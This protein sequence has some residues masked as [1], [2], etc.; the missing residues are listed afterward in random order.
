MI[1]GAIR[2]L[3]T[4]LTGYDDIRPMSVSDLSAFESVGE[5][6]DYVQIQLNDPSFVSL[7]F[8]RNLRLIQ[9]R[10]TTQYAWIRRIVA[11]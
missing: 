7:R 8:L 4:S 10:R 3:Q 11:V 5:V 2:I 1:Q 6:T 9:G